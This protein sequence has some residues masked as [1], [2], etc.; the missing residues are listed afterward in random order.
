VFIVREAIANA[1]CVVNGPSHLVG[2]DES[3][4]K[5]FT[6]EVHWLPLKDIRPEVWPLE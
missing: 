2:H 6:G 5:V 1:Y 4:I 3:A